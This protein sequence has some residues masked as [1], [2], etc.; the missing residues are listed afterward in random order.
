MFV[1]LQSTVY[2]GLDNGGV[3]Q[4]AAAIFTSLVRKIAREEPLVFKLLNGRTDSNTSRP[5]SPGIA[6]Q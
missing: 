3:K 6:L 4:K 1:A 5:E 2:S